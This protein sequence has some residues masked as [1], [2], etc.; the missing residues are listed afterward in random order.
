MFHCTLVTNYYSWSWCWIFASCQPGVVPRR[1]P[2]QMDGTWRWSARWGCSL[3]ALRNEEEIIIS[4]IIDIRKIQ[5]KH[6]CCLNLCI[7]GPIFY[8]WKC[9]YLI[10]TDNWLNVENVILCLDTIRTTMSLIAETFPLIRSINETVD[11]LRCLC[12]WITLQGF[13]SRL[14][15]SPWH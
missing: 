13:L 14:T 8:F 7:P 6:Q 3:R 2:L 9:I 5:V 11:I 4:N 15:I 1:W 10:P 12:L